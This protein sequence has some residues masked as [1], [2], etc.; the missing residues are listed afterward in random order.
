MAFI[1]GKNWKKSELLSFIGDPGQIAGAKPFEYTEGKAQGVRGVSVNTGSG[2][3]FSILPGR[4]MDIPEAYFKGTALNFTS[5]TGI[6]SPAYYEEPG[7]GWLRS[8]YAGLLTTCG[9]TNSG[10]PGDDLGE[11]FG[12]HGRVANAAAENICVDQRWDGDEF[13][14]SIKGMIREAKA[15]FENLSLTRTIETRLGWKGFRLTDV[16]VNNGFEPQP[17][18]MLYHFNFGFPL[19]GPNAK[20]V[21]PVIDT[22]PRDEEAKKDRGVQDCFKF[23]GPVEGYAEKVFFHDLAA[24][25]KG[26]TFAALL[27]KDIG[28]GTPMGIVLRFNKKE[29]PAFTQWKMPRKGFYVLGLEPGT[30]VPLGRG[31]LRELNKL[32][33]I[34]GQESRS[35]T[36]E[37]EVLE[38]SEEMESVERESDRLLKNR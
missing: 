38:T 28:D 12:I 6:T 24:D 13:I 16:I 33:F 19:L 14:I 25:S 9:I 17:L 27:N 1:L 4:G 21:C 3:L 26:N 32:P 37:F 35:I 22:E 11:P 36:V 2:L 30:A 7:L 10:A 31:R 18:L 15:L 29:A 8:F 20:I 23:Q 34:A 5:G